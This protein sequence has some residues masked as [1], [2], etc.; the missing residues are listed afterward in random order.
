MSSLWMP[1][2]AA[3]G[4]AFAMAE[5]SDVQ[6][7]VLNSV[8]IGFIF[9]I[10]EAIYAMLPQ[11]ARRSYE[12]A[13]LSVT[14]P[15]RLSKGKAYGKAY[16]GMLCLSSAGWSIFVYF[17]QTTPHAPLSRHV[18][19]D[20]SWDKP[21]NLFFWVLAMQCWTR[22]VIYAVAQLHMAS[23]EGSLS[24]GPVMKC[25]LVLQLLM[26]AVCGSP[27]TY[28]FLYR[29]FLNAAFGFFW[30]YVPGSPLVDCLDNV[31]HDC[32]LDFIPCQ[33]GPDG[34]LAPDGSYTYDYTYDAK[35]IR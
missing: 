32:N 22:A 15:L 17:Q 3:L 21:Y 29:R 34:S 20:S 19:G 33:L 26:T 5:A 24:T 7:V 31:G 4:T 6:D 2:F 10:D 18:H 9:D 35:F 23:L 1:I 16:A 12:Q 8:A 14:T 27:F 13:P 25:S 30:I 11:K 28:H